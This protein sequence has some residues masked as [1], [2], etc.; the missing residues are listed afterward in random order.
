VFVDPLGHLNIVFLRSGE[1]PFAK[2]GGAFAAVKTEDARD[3][4][5]VG[6]QG[7]FIC[8]GFIGHGMIHSCNAEAGDGNIAMVSTYSF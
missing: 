4:T 3:V 2:V 8:V 6:P 7:R 5:E 1:V